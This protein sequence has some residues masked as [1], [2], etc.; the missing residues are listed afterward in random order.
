MRKKGKVLDNPLAFS[1]IFFLVGTLGLTSG[2]M[3][4]IFVF[5]LCFFIPWRGKYLLILP[6]LILTYWYGDLIRTGM[7]HTE[8]QL[9][10]IMGDVS[11]G[12]WGE[13]QSIEQDKLLVTYRGIQIQVRSKY[14]ATVGSFVWL[15][16]KAKP[17]ENFSATFNYTGYMHMK[18]IWL[19]MRTYTPFVAIEKSTVQFL[20]P[21]A[22]MDVTQR[23]GM[24]WTGDQAGWIAGVLIGS[25]LLLSD[26]LEDEFRIT[27][28]AHTIALSGFNIT[29]IGVFLQKVLFF[30]HKRLR[31]I[32]TIACITLFVLFVGPSAPVVRAAIMGSIGLLALMGGYR[33]AI[34][35]IL[36]ASCF[37]MNIV[38][39]YTLIYDIGFQLSAVAVLGLIWGVPVV[40]RWGQWIPE[41]FGLRET[42]LG[43]IA[44]QI[45]TLPI[46]LY[47][48]GTF[49]LV[50]LP[51]N[52]LI[53][54]WISLM[55]LLSGGTILL[56]YLLPGSLALFPAV[57]T[58][59][60]VQILLQGISW[61]ASIPGAQLTIPPFFSIWWFF[62]TYV[63]IGVL[64]IFAFLYFQQKAP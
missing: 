50:N 45:W 9:P 41:H 30:L 55:M 19:E 11:N 23:I 12:I 6:L 58:G 34:L 3:E 48:F 57:I 38:H 25:K 26:S 52:I 20:L 22:R 13:V 18:N 64:H 8:R 17:F 62:G 47:Y 54:P 1:V 63:V 51:A 53:S 27:G 49:S 36:L 56:S 42:V 32:V 33:V 43:S 28:L 15:Q 14:T 59:Y 7:E 35:P 31:L 4:W 60:V 10:Q 29:I 37:L 61:L 24:L 5:L 46:S 2:C 44:V 16:G 21:L 40:S 39:P